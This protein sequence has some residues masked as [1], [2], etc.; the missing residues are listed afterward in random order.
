MNRHAS[1]NHVYRLIWSTV[2]SVWIP[3]EDNTR[4]R[5]K[6]ASRVLLAATLSL[7]AAYAHA[8]G[9][10]GGQVTAGTGS[11]AQSG[12]T[13]TITQGSPTLSL[14][15]TSFNIASQETV[16]FV[17]PSASAIAVNRIFDTNGTQI[18]GHLNANGQVFLINPNGIVFG[19]G[20]QVNVGGLVA[21]TLDLNAPGSD[22]N[23]K[24][25]SGNSN[26][27]VVNEGTINAD[28]GGYVVL[29]GS[30]VSNQGAITAQLGTVALA[31][32]SAAT[33]TFSDN[34]LVHLQVDQSVWQSLAENGGLIRAD[35][36]QVIMTAGAKDALLASVVN[37]TGVIEARTVENHDG[38]I[39][40]L[41]GM[42]AGTVN[43]GGTL[44]ASASNGG[45]GGFIETSAAHV[46]VAADARVTTAA[47]MGR[48]GS[49]LIDP[50]DFTIAASGGDITGAALSSELGTTAVVVESSAGLT[51]G[52]GNVNVNDA[53]A[54]SANTALTLT[55]SN[56]V[57]INADI[58][59]TGNTA[60][61]VINPNTANG[62]AT[63]SGT[64]SYILH[65]GV[66]ITLPGTTPS[67]SIAGTHYTVI[68][69][70]GLSGSMT[71]TDLQ[72]I[73]V[74]LSGDYVLG[75]NINA[76]A[77]AGWHAGAGFTPI[78][79]LGTPF[80][81]IFD[82]LG[83]TISN[84]TIS[85][86]TPN[87][88][89][90]G[91]TGTG[92]TIRNVGL[93]S[94]SV[95]GGAGT[96]GLV[97]NNGP[98]VAISGSYTTGPVNGAAGTGGLVGS[99]TSGA[100]SGSYS[101]GSVSGAAGTGG[102]I[103]SST[104]GAITDSYATGSVNGAAGTGGLI[105]S[106][107]TGVI[108]DSYSTGGV[109]GAA[110]T[111]GLIGSSTSG[112]IT[113]SYATG[114]V[115]GAAGTGG[116]IGSNTSGPISDSYATGNVNGGTGA[117]VGGLIG[118]NTS[119]TVINSY[120]AGAVSGTGAGVGALLGSSVVGVVTDSYWNNTTSLV[121]SSAGGGIGMTPAQM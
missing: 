74:L 25:F 62:A 7:G 56:N 78:G 53:V 19:P 54:W 58:T 37:N 72:G 52:S 4:G 99:N 64:G 34:S 51:A 79:T 46:E 118:S 24:V 59:A 68:N 43:V 87:V 41:G 61:L 80:T 40:L 116:L 16:D 113:G 48:Y 15:W 50:Q 73:N 95:T 114:S 77:T 81:G 92:A 96:G 22:A 104:S 8:G 86:T 71:G 28:P 49:W 103:G 90:F 89:L 23:A 107:T 75:S 17:Q 3:G 26:E 109:S 70:L 6:R 35:G 108:S 66:S 94:D 100:I 31:A 102:L 20:A 101:T 13:T 111:G 65:S 112:A 84:L 11:I 21:A 76:A 5:G 91:A 18:L 105:G 39:T 55:A 1:M 45:N 115:N 93:V 47:V 57:N 32:G 12:A 106:S 119:G 10:S 82:G 69:T 85:L 42:M 27:S 9:P 88:G 33:L 121:Q 29:L 117:G 67:L 60:G 36:G 120:A 110:G 97:G 44:D 14:S 83:H 30:H 63:A 38:T 98:G 2:R